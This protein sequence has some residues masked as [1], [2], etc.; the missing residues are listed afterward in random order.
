M[1][2]YFIKIFGQSLNKNLKKCEKISNFKNKFLYVL[3]S[4][5][6]AIY[7]RSITSLIF[8]SNQL[9]SLRNFIIQVYAIFNRL[10]N[11]GYNVKYLHICDF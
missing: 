8:Q 3:L 4:R 7:F 6:E 10:Y 1:N 5:N 2:G 11:I 9:Y